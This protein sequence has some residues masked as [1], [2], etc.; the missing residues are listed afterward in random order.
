VCLAGCIVAC[1]A[2]GADARTG[3]KRMADTLAALYAAAVANP[4]GYE[5][6]NRER[7]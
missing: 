3:T 2:P 6:L 5:F 4:G 7:A 1:Q